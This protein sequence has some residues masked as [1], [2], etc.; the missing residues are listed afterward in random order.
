MVHQILHVVV[1]DNGADEAIFMDGC[2]IVSAEP[3]F[4]DV[5]A[6][7]QT[8]KALA[9]FFGLR[10]VRCEWPAHSDWQWDEVAHDLKKEGLMHR[11]PLAG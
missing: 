7:R 6:V 2:L 5:L 11:Q 9:E 3:D 8:G 1:T 4:G 10:L